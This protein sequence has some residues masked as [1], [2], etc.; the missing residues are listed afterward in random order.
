MPAER[1]EKTPVDYV[2]LILTPAL[3]MTLVG[4]LVF[5][6]IELLYAGEFKD[7]LRLAFFCYVFGAVL[8]ARISMMADIASRAPIYGGILAV[9]SWIVL[10]VYIQYDSGSA[11]APFSWLINMVLIGI[12]W[13]S[14][15]RLTWDCTNIDT[16]A[17]DS[18]EGLLE[19]AGLEPKS[20]R[21]EDL[22]ARVEEEA[23]DPPGWAGVWARYQRYREKRK[24]NRPLGVWVVYFALATLPI[25]GLGQALL[26]VDDAQRRTNVFWLMGIYVASGLALLLTT[27]FLSLRRYLRQ[28]NVDMPVTMTATW[29]TTGGAIILVLL[30]LGALLPRPAAEYSVLDL[31]PLRSEDRHASRFSP[32]KGNAGKDQGQPDGKGEQNK[33]GG[34]GKESGMKDG[35][36][37]GKVQDKAES[38]GGDKGQKDKGGETSSKEGKGGKSGKDGKDAKSEKDGGNSKD[39]GNDEKADKEKSSSSSSKTS[40]SSTNNPVQAISAAMGAVATILKW[41]VFAVVALIVVFVVL[42]HGL[43][44]LANFSQWARDLL[45]SLR[46]FWEGLF[47]R[48][49]K[50]SGARDG[51]KEEAKVIEEAVPFA[52]FRNPFS[53]G[54]AAQRSPKELLRYSFAALE[55]WA[56][57]CDL[58]RLPQETPM[59]F[60][61]RIAEEAP[62]LAEDVRRFIGLYVWAEYAR[63]PLPGD[64]AEVVRR[65]WQRLEAAAEQPLSA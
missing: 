59:E 43:S 25:F 28:R 51:V 17:G 24:K 5:F 56:R 1:S 13:W 37:S 20:A 26:A 32:G 45:A 55:A 7:R 46:K 22:K 39:S 49:D 41:V 57:D 23:K 14:T 60:A 8:V 65:L 42:R 29:L 2:L 50:E 9:L 21:I 35:K 33:D 30:V 48:A 12:V 16:E 47:G 10:Q 31:N 64:L 15:H 63:G 36:N 61:A 58:A 19:A 44:F 11:V 52:A 53:D 62:A 27:C 18:G 6:L 3:I 34:D 54:T 40:S 4:S 38:S